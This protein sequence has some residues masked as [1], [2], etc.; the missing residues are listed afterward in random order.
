M[1]IKKIVIFTI[2]ILIQNKLMEKNNQVV[3]NESTYVPFTFHS[4]EKK[5]ILWH[6]AQEEKKYPGASFTID[7]PYLKNID[8]YTQQ[9]F[10]TIFIEKTKKNEKI[11]NIFNKNTSLPFLIFLK[12]SFPN[13]D[14]EIK[15]IIF[16]IPQVNS[17]PLHSKNNIQ[18][19]VLPKNMCELLELFFSNHAT[20][21]NLNNK[22]SLE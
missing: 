11:I 10:L 12:I 13:G 4:D 19:K 18:K 3:E 14:K 22:E 20:E 17:I 8:K 15:S 6:L 7:D 2:F 9:E 5:D 16:N 1:I 21:L